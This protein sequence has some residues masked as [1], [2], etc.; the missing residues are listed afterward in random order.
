M[1]E[2]LDHLALKRLAVAW[3]WR[4]G[5]RVV[6]TE[7]QCPF[8]RYRIDVAGWFDRPVDGMLERAARESASLWATPDAARKT[9]AKGPDAW[10]TII[11]ECK[12]S[13]A[14]FVR[15]GC[16]PDALLR[17]RE[18]LDERKRTMEETRVK[19]FEPS[20]RSEGSSL[21]SEL[22]EWNFGNSKMASYRE[23]LRDLQ[24]VDA[25]LYGQTKFAR[26]ARYRLADR[27]VLFAPAGMIRA[28][29]LPADWGLIEC[30]KRPLRRG[31]AD[32][33]RGV[34][35]L[36]DLPLRETLAPPPLASHPSRR[37][38][39]FRTIAIAASREAVRRIA[40]EAMELGRS[41]REEG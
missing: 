28:R 24:K 33:A 40:P 16:D 26:F 6:A 37:E 19:L 15:D 8:G 32:F 17:A 13:R 4:L 36:A 23:V 14:D 12:Q 31:K 9:S 41:E 29:E 22:D 18:R 7:V 25:S 5:C 39:L 30:H 2:T 35:P 1:A 10:R 20:L 27:L 3:L 34:D 21:F 11:V 38:R